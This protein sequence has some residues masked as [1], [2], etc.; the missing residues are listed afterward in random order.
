[1][2]ILLSGW[3]IAI[4][5]IDWLAVVR[6]RRRLEYFAKPAAM[7]ALL[8]WLW[9]DGPAT[10][11]KA[12]LAWFAIGLVCSLAGDVLLLL[13]E[14][15]FLPGLVAFLLAHLAYIVGLNAGG[16]L[17]LTEALL[18]IPMAL[19]GGWLVWRI[20]GSLRAKG[21][22]KLVIPVVLYTIVISLMVVSAV[23]T[24]FRSEWPVGPATLVSIGATLFFLSDAVLAW[25]RFVAPV[26]H[27]KVLVIVAYHLGQMA[28]ILGA[29]RAVQPPWWVLSAYAGWVSSLK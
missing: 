18:A 17:W 15:F 3:P 26:P 5:A 16:I 8:A 23:A 28:L 13:P 4:M 1:M 6:S 27:G 24:L 7:L 2:E 22:S 19:I 21:R 10:I 20:G 25:N 12:P 9:I 11:G 29:A 14:R